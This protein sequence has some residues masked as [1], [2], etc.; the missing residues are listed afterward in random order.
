MDGMECGREL[1][2]IAHLTEQLTEARALHNQ[3]AMQRDKARAAIIACRGVLGEL[4][5]GL[6]GD[7]SDLA[8]GVRAAIMTIKGEP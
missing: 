4:A 3:A 8:R 7:E 1:E 6:V 5:H 2:R